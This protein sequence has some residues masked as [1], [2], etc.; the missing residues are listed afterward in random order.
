M[1]YQSI[2]IKKIIQQIGNNE[3][4]L[5]ALQRHFVWDYKKIEML[6]DSLMKDYP[7][8]TFLFWNVNKEKANEYTFYKF[9]SNYNERTNRLNLKA[10][11]PEM[12]DRIIGVLDGQQRLSSMYIALQ[13]TYAYKLPRKRVNNPEAYPVR[14]LYLDI[15]KGVDESKSEEVYQFKFLTDSQINQSQD[16]CNSF[17]F[18]V[19]EVLK[20]D[21]EDEIDNYVDEHSQL[22]RTSEK[23]L[24]KLWRSIMD[25]QH[26]LINYFEINTPNL[27]NILDIFV[28]VNSTGQPLS[29]SDL[30]FSTIVA[31]WDDAREKME[32]LIIK[33]N[34][35]GEGFRFNTDYI[36]RACL[37]LTD[38][39]I[40]FKV[41]TFKKENINKIKCNWLKISEALL[42]VVD[43]LVE[44]GFSDETLTSYNSTLPI[45][46]YIY[47]GGNINEIDKENMRKYLIISML[48]GIF[49]SHGDAILRE[50]RKAYKEKNQYNSFDIEWIRKL[51]FSGDK[52]YSLT[53]EDI[54]E[55]FEDNTK[56]AYTFMILS[57]LYP[58]LKL[59]Q[60]KF[61]QDHI[62]PYAGFSKDKLLKLGINQD[63]IKRWM[64]MR[65]KLANLQLLEGSENQS[66]Q[67]KSLKDWI[68]TLPNQ[69][70]Y[71]IDNYIPL[72]CNL[73]LVNFDDFYSERKKLMVN[74]IKNII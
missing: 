9:I 14:S 15:L 74:A 33:M 67:N 6:F 13:G 58:H 41:Q 63:D 52:S 20:W 12:K 31:N 4:Y 57:L 1:G 60:V 11:K 3:V 49:G 59:N 40:L 66:K 37:M 71:K 25:P 7:I 65:D 69:D 43:I 26:P 39:P 5:P 8:G 32:A 42:H 45:A 36:I 21:N 70:K 30:L 55:I 50:F 61:H 73:E 46:Y 34:E 19:K 54:E 16:N 29:K 51:K 64:E 56:N 48:N 17:W 28:R 62:H 53:K 24:H 35:K 47:Q 38:C 2:T 27:D 68:T 10:E 72:N 18:P 23:M 44:F 22:T